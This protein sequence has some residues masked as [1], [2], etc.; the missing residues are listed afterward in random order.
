MLAR[1]LL[2]TFAFQTHLSVLTV[3]RIRFCLCC[4]LPFNYPNVRICRLL[5]FPQ[6]RYRWYNV[7]ESYTRVLSFSDESKK[8]R[9]AVRSAFKNNLKSATDFN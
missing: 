9:A 7:R 2:Q 4:S 8:F 5:D 3:N 6:D 1:F